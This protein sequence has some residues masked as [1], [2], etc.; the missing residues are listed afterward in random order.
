MWRGVSSVC[1]FVKRLFE[2]GMWRFTGSSNFLASVFIII[3][4]VNWVG[5]LPR[6]FRVSRHFLFRVS[7][8]VPLWLCTVIINFRK[9]PLVKLGWFIGT[10]VPIHLASFIGLCEVVRGIMRP[11]A[12][13]LRLGANM[14]A[15]HVI[16]SLVRNCS[17]Y[18]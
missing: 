4:I 6:T 12:L 8:S 5:L 18:R 15:G 13:G 7:L 16:T 2:A 1:L 17:I 3:L 10:G 11:I 14:L 9:A